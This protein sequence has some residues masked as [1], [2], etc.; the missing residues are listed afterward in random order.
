M[1]HAEP[2]AIIDE[3]H[4]HVERRAQRQKYELL[5]PVVAMHG[6]LGAVD[7]ANAECSEPQQGERRPEV[8]TLP[9]GDFED[10]QVLEWRLEVHGAAVRTAM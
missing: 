1:H 6:E 4:P 8:P 10:A 2:E 5:D 7:E 3:R 9:R